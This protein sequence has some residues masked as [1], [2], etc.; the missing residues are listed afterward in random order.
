M[1]KVKTAAKTFISDKKRIE[2]IVVSTMEKISD[3]V[4][5]SLGPG[6]RPSIIESEV[7]G[8][9]N[10][11]TKDGVTIFKSLGSNDVNEH[12][13]I[14]TARDA[15]I[16]TANSTGDGCQ[17]ASAI[18]YTPKGPTTIGEL[19]VGQQICGTDGTVQVV[20]G[21][22]HKGKRDIYNIYF[23][24]GGMTSCSPDHL[25]TVK[26]MSGGRKKTLPLSEIEKDYKGLLGNKYCVQT[27]VV[28][29]DE[30]KSKMPLD[31]YFLGVL[32]GDGCLRDSGSIEITIG[33]PKEHIIEKLILPEGATQLVRWVENKNSYRIKFQ[34]VRKHV[35]ELNVANCDSFSKHIPP[36]YLYSSIE[37]RRSLLQ[38][39][40]DTDGHVNKRGLFEFSTVSETLSRDFLSLCRGL[41]IPV[42]HRTKTRKEGESYSTTPLHVITQRK[43]YK[44]GNAIEKIEKT[45]KVDDV[46]CIKVSNPDSLYITD[47]YI[48]TH[49]TTNTTI[50][51]GSIIKN[52]FAFCAKNPHYSPQKA[53]RRISKCVK[54]EIL[55]LI[56]S[57]S[58]KIGQENKHLLEK[59][60]TISANGDTEMAKAVIESYDAVGYGSGSH[61]T[62][63]E[64]SG[65]QKY[66]VE[67]I[68]GFPVGVGYEDCCGKFHNAFINDQANQRCLL[69]NPLFLLYDGQITDLLLVKDVLENIGQSYVNGDTNFKNLVLVSHGFSE[70]V[71]T[72]LA[73]NFANPGTI[74]VYPMITPM[75]H[76]INSQYQ[77]LL[78]LSAFTGAKIFGMNRHPSEATE[79]DFGTGMEIFESFRFRSTVVGSPDPINVEVRAE[80]LKKQIENP[81]SQWEKIILEERLGKLTSGIAKLKIYGGSDGE[82]KEKHDRVEDAVCSVRN[83]IVDG[84]LPGGCRTH[85]D[86]S[87]YL[88][89]KYDES[90][91]LVQVLFYS[92]LAP[93]KKLLDNVGYNDDEINEVISHLMQNPDDVYDVSEQKYGKAEEFGLFDATGAVTKSLENAVSISG[94][95]GT[96]GGIIA[97]PRDDVM[98]R[99]WAKEEREYKQAAERPESFVNEANLRA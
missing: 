10:R 29:F 41:G 34:N 66:E 9:P 63:Q 43:G 15:A 72:E 11:V 58:I 75:S 36:S 37:S 38:G 98:E 57:K 86:L 71:L 5:S 68:E 22:F 7:N 47:D 2:K 51:V 77:F 50:L 30:D 13:I 91:V 93:I 4:G 26:T 18:V 1:K 92:L 97:Y 6:G 95:L 48:V 94:V 14:E 23:S 54:D 82:L 33:K 56:E 81:S 65:P 62:I 31:P 84:C 45:G 64:L 83:A 96:L 42:S 40:I 25:W 80:E 52:L 20:E 44:Y 88:I 24:G 61:I 53:M 46:M 39:L 69:D 89:S 49:N 17:L 19:Q 87:L 12:L 59:V 28:H 74:N 85:I 16:R 99:E 55:P 90:D 78:D 27:S 32:L 3:I 79:K 76:Q 21:I 70:S 35:Q 60:A 8:I 67:L 73:M